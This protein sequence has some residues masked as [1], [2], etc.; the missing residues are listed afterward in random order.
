MRRI[1]LA[2]LTATVAWAPGAAAQDLGGLVDVCAAGGADRARCTELAVTSRALQGDLGL[3][4]GLGSAVPGS[5]STLGKRLGST[6]RVAI[7]ARAAF[8]HV[9][10][11]DLS[12]PG[13]E[14]SR[15]TSFVVPAVHTG[16]TVGV[17]DGFSLMPTVG[18]FL[19]L[20]LLG[21]ASFAFLPSGEGFDGKTSAWSL[22]ARL[23][24]LRESFTLPGVSVSLV[25]RSIG[26]V[27][28][29]ALDTGGGD[30][31][32]DP[33][34]TSIRATVGK[35]LL[36]VGLLAGVG[37]DRL[38]GSTTVH[39]LTPEGATAEAS[40]SSFRQT[41]TLIFGGA[42]MNFLVLQL[43][44]EAGWGRGF[45]AVT[46]YRGAPFDPGAGTFYGSVAFRLT[47]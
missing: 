18:G 7:H 28:Y 25:R 15:E 1:A 32:V 21:Q 45:G 5:A 30:V 13:P 44:A 12:D 31:T 37:W 9:G 40:S 8:A 29:G 14:P 47:I 46:G 34:V 36:S 38:G 20:D 39:A 22:G 2:V 16:V 35:D 42:A 26:A 17:F 6:P 4:T 27:Q 3:L 10:L 19:S 24:I 41:R 43:S 33:A 23:G 11:P